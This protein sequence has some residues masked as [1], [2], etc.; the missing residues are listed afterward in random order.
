MIQPL[1]VKIK[2]LF[3][4]RKS[5]TKGII[6]CRLQLI[7]IADAN[8]SFLYSTYNSSKFWSYFVSVTLISSFEHY[9]AIITIILQI[10]SPTARNMRLL[11]INVDMLRMTKSKRFWNQILFDLIPM[12]KELLLVMFVTSKWILRY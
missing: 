2:Q 6:Q 12:S 4:V 7:S 3:K 1:G 11:P 5:I 8:K 10:L 9:L